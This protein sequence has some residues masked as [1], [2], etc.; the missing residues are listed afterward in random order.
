MT[1]QKVLI[2]IPL[3]LIAGM[4]INSWI[5]ILTTDILPVWRH[6]TA[7]LLFL[8]LPYL[9]FKSLKTIILGTGLFLIAGIFNVYTLT[10]DVVTDIF[11]IRIGS[12]EL[13][14]LGFQPWALKL[15]IVYGILNFSPLINYYLDYR[16]SKRKAVKK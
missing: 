10:T 15:F 16:E 7:I 9:F 13:N 4:I 12:L 11:G 14:T 2:L 5:I 6:Y 1:K 3:C 8:P